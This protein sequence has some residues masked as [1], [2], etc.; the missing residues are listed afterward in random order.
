MKNKKQN[1]LVRSLLAAILIFSFA[2]CSEYFQN[3]LEDK[4]TGEDI[5]LMLIDFNFFKTR[6]T[7]KLMDA[8]TGSVINEDAVIKFSGKNGN[9][10]VTFAGE[11]KPEFYTSQG[12]LELTVDP[13]VSVSESSPLEYSVMVEIDGYNTLTKG[14]QIKSEG[15]K[16]YELFLSKISDEEE[17]DLS[18]D[19][20]F[21]D[22]DTTFNFFV[23]QTLFKSALAEEKSYSIKYSIS[24]SDLKKFTD[25]N[26][27]LLFQNSQEVIDAYNS[28][29]E[30]FLKVSILTFSDY[31]REIDLVNID[32]TARNVLF[33]KLET[34]NL[35][36][37][38]VAGKTVGNLNN[39]VISSK[40]EYLNDPL[41]DIFGF[42][43]FEDGHW[44]ILGNTTVYNTLPFSYTL[45]EA[46][47]DLLCSKGSSI[48]FKS[49]VISS[50]SF[51]ADVYNSNNEFIT[52]I[53]FRGK[54]P[55]TFVVE[56][57]PAEAVKLV[58]RNNNPSFEN[59]SPLEIPNFCDGSYE[60]NVTPAPN[61]VEYQ[62]T[63]KAM[64][65]NTPTV[66]IA[67]T[68]SVDVKL[69]NT[70]DPWQSVHM[71]GGVVDLLGIPNSEYE[72][73]LLWENEW[74]YS[75]Y[76]TKFDSNG[77]YLGN[78]EEDA[79]V[80]SKVLSDGRIQINIEK[81]F[82]QDICDELGW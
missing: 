63:M 18:G 10:I 16:S 77:N 80:K 2:G 15:I 73:R 36:S 27:N 23:P 66:A 56:D 45:V 69:K 42:A 17:T 46:S 30:N 22:N 59:L 51:D 79:K 9:D 37:L 76:S 7:Y 52:S 26:N 32:G 44:N 62:I 81:I 6:M 74:E 4:E 24:I 72:I 41:P 60:I 28:D 14:I 57:V 25:T 33:H 78:P 19:V 43:K 35:K 3:P 75:T 53:N 49:D 29:P 50:F 48:T 82:S 8:R 65:K 20:D 55:E 67:P 71:E 31:Q 21:G 68:Y 47:E 13:N 58:F 61:Y 64:C 54:I 38:V 39:G 11:K 1:N 40:C 70:D 12:Q 5:R 34:G